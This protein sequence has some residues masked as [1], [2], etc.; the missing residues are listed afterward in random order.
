MEGPHVMLLAI[1]LSLSARAL[2]ETETSEASSLQGLYK[3]LN[4][5]PQL[6]GWE[7]G[8]PCAESWKGISCLGRSVT[9][10][11]IQGLGIRGSLGI[12][13][14]ALSSLKELDVSDNNIGEEDEGNGV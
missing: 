14:S 6:T 9:T 3:S 2:A 7:G 5:P 4:I 8:D 12:E 13:F 1:V 11:K 10:I